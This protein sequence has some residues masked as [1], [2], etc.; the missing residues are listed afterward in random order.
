[1]SGTPSRADLPISLDYEDLRPPRMDLSRIE[2]QG[3]QI[4]RRRWL[5]TG[6]LA[7]AVPVA[8]GVTLQRAVE[9]HDSVPQVIGS[10]ATLGSI[11]GDPFLRL[12]PPV[13]Q[14][15]VID[16]SRAPWV[17]FAWLTTTSEFCY[18]AVPSRSAGVAGDCVGVPHVLT[19]ARP[20]AYLPLFVVDPPPTQHEPRAPVVGLVRG[21]AVTVD[22]TMFGRTTTARIHRFAVDSAAPVGAYL[23][24]VPIDGHQSYGDQD[25]QQLVARDAVGRIVATYSRR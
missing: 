24:W 14:P 12:H 7:L 8:V 19:T 22:I 2:R 18:A 13:G 25:V 15:V 23:A 6:V 11:E 9:S 1:V 21:D 3:R 16:T 4:R 5:A 10:R 17:T 20:T